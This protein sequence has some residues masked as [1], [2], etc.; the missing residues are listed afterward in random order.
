MGKRELTCDVAVLGGGPGGIPAALAAA[1]HGASVILCER[2][3]YLGGNAATG[4]PLLG[5]L[6][7]GGRQIIGGIAQEFIDDLM[8]SGDSF[9]HECCPLHNSVT[10]VHPDRFRLLALKKCLEAGV[11]LLFHTEV[12]GAVVKDGR[13][14]KAI[15]TGKGDQVE[16]SAKVFIDATG[17]GDLAYIAG[18]QYEKGSAIDHMLQ[19]PTL[20]FSVT[21]FNKEKLM[22]FLEAH[23]ENM[24]QIDTVSVGEGYNTK[25]WRSTD[26]YVFVGMKAYLDQIRKK[27]DC[28]ILREN[29]IIINSTIPGKVFLNIV[30]I[31]NCDCSDIESLSDAEVKAQLQV[32]GIFKILREYFPGFENAVL[33]S[34]SPAIGV[35][36]TRRFCGIEK[37]TVDQALAG[38]KPENTIALA[39]YKIDIHSGKWEGTLL[40]EVVEPYGIPLGSLISA[41][42]DGLLFS[43]RCI[44]VDHE[45][46]GSMRV[47]PT[48]M[49]IGQGAGTLAACA[50][51]QG[52]SPKDVNYREVVGILLKDK[53]ILR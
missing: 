4:L 39:G 27:T 25:L 1:R 21:G 14:E 6:S 11:R 51:R 52:I 18:A 44:S 45:T 13:L 49:A 35:R 46:L 50:A 10:L 8:A 16:I 48:C 9:G 26:T 36:E 15:V 24:K 28:P 22:D 37:V 31:P 47:M 30:R 42:L 12:T 20:L 7:Q 38:Y 29:I 19:P 43:G 32:E 34:I 53:A 5:Y 2:N 41:D 23:P 40:Q 33:D 17:D 3:G